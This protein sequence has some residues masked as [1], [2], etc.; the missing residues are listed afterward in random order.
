MLQKYGEV[1]YRVPIDLGFG[2][3][4]RKLPSAE[5]NSSPGANIGGCS[6]CPEDGARARQTARAPT[7]AEQVSSAIAFAKDRYGAT[8]FMAY[9]QAYTGTFA[10]TSQLRSTFE[11]IL[12]LAHFEAISIGTR[13]DCLSE[14]TICLLR[15]LNETCEVWVELGVQTSHDHTLRLINRGH[16]WLCSKTAIERLASAGLRPVAHVILGLPGENLADNI[17][18]AD[19]LSK[20]PLFGI[21]IHNLHLLRNTPLATQYASNPFPL[22]MEYE[23]SETLIAFLRRVPPHIPIMRLQTDSPED[24]L[25]APKWSI[26]KPQFIAMVQRQMELAGV[27]QGDLLQDKDTSVKASTPK[28]QVDIAFEQAEAEYRFLGPARLEEH[29]KKGDVYI[30]DIGFGTGVRAFE[31]WRRQ[32]EL[33]HAHALHIRGLEINRNYLRSHPHPLGEVLLSKGVFVDSRAS[34]TVHWGDARHRLNELQK[35]GGLL[36][37]FIFIDG[38]GAQKNAELWTQNFFSKLLQLLTPTG[39]ILTHNTTLPVVAG[40]KSLALNIA[41]TTHPLSPKRG[42]IA[43]RLSLDSY[44]PLSSSDV[45]KLLKSSLGIPYR[46][47]HLVWTSKEILR[48]RADEVKLWKDSNRES[49]RQAQLS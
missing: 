46:D 28:I 13:P 33:P 10:S 49:S 14:A 15:E 34:I 44:L 9:I 36:F 21:K 11:E 31:A 20:L 26:T 1:L 43:S 4:H 38:F 16:D 2:C 12:S 48:H 22:L 35:D 29:L 37:D 32:S 7:I 17:T 25:I 8:K 39:S 6:F 47:P 24:H 18:T 5:Q 19:R 30:L 23:Y 45:E 3:P 27:R 40:L 41:Y 42:L